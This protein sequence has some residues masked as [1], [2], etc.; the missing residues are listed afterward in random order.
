MI[1]LKKKQQAATLKLRNPALE[2]AEMISV[3]KEIL[4]LQLKINDLSAP[5]TS[6]P[7]E[8]R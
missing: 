2:T 6:V 7:T 5:A 3:Q 4:D 8:L 1:D